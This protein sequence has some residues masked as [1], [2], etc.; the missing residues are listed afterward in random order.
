MDYSLL[1]KRMRE[2]ML[3]TQTEM[4]EMLRVSFATVN[5]WERGHHVPTIKQ[6]RAIRD[7]CKKKRIKTNF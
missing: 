7:F 6:Q 5:R 4:A 2:E 3:V 1:I